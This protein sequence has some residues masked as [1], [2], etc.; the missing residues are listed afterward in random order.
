MSAFNDPRYLAAQGMLGAPTPIDFDRPCA[1]CGYNLKGLFV[2][3]VCPECGRPIAVPKKRMLD[4]TLVD[5]PRDFLVR[6]ASALTLAFIGLALSVFGFFTIV[7]TTVVNGVL[8][9]YRI[10]GHNS[11]LSPG[12][13]IVVPS[14]PDKAYA[15]AFLLGAAMWS[16]GLFIATLPR[17]TPPDSQENRRAEWKRLRIASNAVQ[18][19]WLLAATLGATV[20]FATPATGYGPQPPAWI[21]PAMIAAILAIIVGVA[22]L[23]PTSV[24]L[25]RYAD[26]VPDN[27]LSWRLR[28]SAWSIA[29][30]GTL[31]V[32]TGITPPGLPSFAGFIAFFL[33]LGLAVF[34]LGFLGGLGVQFWSIGQLAAAGWA[35]KTN[36]QIREE[37][38]RRMLEKMQ[39]EKEEAD[40]RA[41]A[42]K[43]HLDEPAPGVRKVGV[44]PRGP[45]GR[46]APRR[47][48]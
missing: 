17:P 40:R 21:G 25:A 16:T 1:G 38:D 32:L 8:G 34:W 11:T 33:W 35:A 30:F 45:D 9:F 46:P 48:P 3:G 22:G 7:A 31:I 26:W 23:V 18:T 5:A 6:F 24:L 27:E 41:D 39:R 44:A 42:L 13:G 2:G 20:I 19:S 12:R 15:I 10:G 28:T 14:A 36:H 47:K 37:R 4:D 29:V 43:R